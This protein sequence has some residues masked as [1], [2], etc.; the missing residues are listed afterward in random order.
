MNFCVTRILIN[1]KGVVS[2]KILIKKKRALEAFEEMIVNKKRIVLFIFF[3]LS[4]NPKK[5]F[6]HLQPSK[7]GII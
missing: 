4:L 7:K 6:L 3:C 2:F 5:R 1:I